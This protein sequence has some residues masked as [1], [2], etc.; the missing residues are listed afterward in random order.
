M[1][2]PSTTNVLLGIIAT[3]LLLITGKLYNV[4]GTT[5]AYGGEGISLTTPDGKPP[6]PVALYAQHSTGVW[7]PCKISDSDTLLVEIARKP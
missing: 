5:T 2:T 4:S 7:Y 3:C 6:M 1:K